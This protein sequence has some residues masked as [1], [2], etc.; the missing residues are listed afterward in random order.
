MERE[1]SALSFW[2]RWLGFGLIVAVS[3]LAGG[4]QAR[5]AQYKYDIQ[6]KNPA[7]KYGTSG[8]VYVNPSPDVAGAK[9]T[10]LVSF[11]TDWSAIAEIGHSWGSAGICDQFSTRTLTTLH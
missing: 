2:A 9:V 1:R 7:Y 11:R 3:V 5:A 6:V 8:Y 10:G 4:A